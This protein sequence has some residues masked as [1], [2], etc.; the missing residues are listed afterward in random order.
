[1][2]NAN[3]E[4]TIAD[5]VIEAMPFSDE[6]IAWCRKYPDF[7][8]ALKVTNADRFYPLG[9]ITT[10]FTINKPDDLVIG[11][12]AYDMVAKKF[13]QD[14]I[15]DINNQ[16]KEFVLYTNLPSKKYPKNVHHINQFYAVYG[17][18]GDYANTHHVDLQYIL[19]M[20][21]AEL[22]DRATRTVAKSEEIVRSGGRRHV[23]QQELKD[24]LAKIRQAK[25]IATT[26]Y[27]K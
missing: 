21:N 19:A 17:Q 22:S 15:V 14:F 20:D 1:M 12:I 4:I 24:T 5:V 23:S 11:F 16:H 7:K 8:E 13:K 27:N 3:S 18:N 9:M 26:P 6:I 25:N 10:T 2:T